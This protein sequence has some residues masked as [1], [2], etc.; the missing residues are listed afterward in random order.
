MEK[1]NKGPEK[2][3]K[4][5]ISTKF[6]YCYLPLGLFRFSN[7]EEIKFSVRLG[8]AYVKSRIS[9]LNFFKTFEN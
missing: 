9:I 3:N 1:D 2:D 8:A 4:N 5:N 6:N 7:F